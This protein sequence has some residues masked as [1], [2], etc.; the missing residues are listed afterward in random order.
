MPRPSLLRLEGSIYVIHKEP[1]HQCPR[2]RKKLLGLAARALR[3]AIILP[4]HGG[5]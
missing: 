5:V 4:D 2:A 1:R 3:D